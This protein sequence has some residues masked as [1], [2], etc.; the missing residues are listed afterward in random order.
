MLAVEVKNVSKSYDK[1]VVVDN[2]SFEVSGGEIL[3]LIGPNGAGKTTNIRMIMDIIKPDS[4][5]VLIFG[6]RFN[7]DC[8]NLIGYLPEERGLYRK[9][10][11][12]DVMIYLATLKGMDRAQAA[13]RTEELL[14]RVNMQAHKNKK[15]EELSHGM[16]Q[17]IQ[18]LVTFLHDPQILIFDE[19]FTGLDPVNVKVVKDIVLDLKRQ[20]KV[21]MLST[22]R[23]SEV[24]ELCDRIFMINRGKNVLYGAVSDIKARYRN[25]SVIVECQGDISDIAGIK[26]R[27][28]NGNTAELF[29]EIGTTHQQLLERMIARGIQINRFEVST[30]TLNEIFIQVAGETR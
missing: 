23:M 4:G 29:L 21:I 18:L 24:E 8:K 1:K 25:N 11:I 28:M 20:G 17:L 10:K 16:A 27:K 5:E 2:V 15:I 26:S 7:D 30:P 12:A 22:H 9:A 13:R 3:G 14:V 6:K 19:P